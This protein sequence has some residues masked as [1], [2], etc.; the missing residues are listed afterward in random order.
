MNLVKIP[1]ELLK[2]HKEVFLM[3]DTMNQLSI[4]TLD[5]P[6]ISNDIPMIS[7]DFPIFSKN[8]FKDPTSST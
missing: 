5:F 7:N 8:F 3:V 6:I 2:L 1:K 4:V